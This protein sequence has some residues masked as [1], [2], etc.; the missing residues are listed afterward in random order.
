MSAHRL[1]NVS[2]ENIIKLLIIPIKNLFC[3]GKHQQLLQPPKQREWCGGWITTSGSK[4]E[5]GDPVSPRTDAQAKNKHVL[6]FVVIYFLICLCRSV[7]LSLCKSVYLLSEHSH[8]HYNLSNLI[9][10]TKL[11][12]HKAKALVSPVW[13]WNLILTITCV[14]LYTGA[15]ILTTWIIHLKAKEENLTFNKRKYTNK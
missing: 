12:H 8:P 4:V 6:V 9:C 10:H 11:A 7:S 15:D 5:W 3:L 14:N 13:T 2:L 1:G